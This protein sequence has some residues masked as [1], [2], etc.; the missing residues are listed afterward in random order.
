MLLDWTGRELRADKRGAIPEDLALIVERL[1]LNQSN[2]SRSPA[3]D[4]LTSTTAD[5]RADCSDR[6]VGE[7]VGVWIPCPTSGKSAGVAM[8]VP[9]S[10]QNM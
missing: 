9:S 2:F 1:G 8:P 4:R 3:L 5:A 7:S 6:R 10:Q